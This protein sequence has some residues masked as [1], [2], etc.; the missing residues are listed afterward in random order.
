ML[1]ILGLIYAMY[2]NL[3]LRYLPMKRSVFK[4]TIKVFD[5][6]ACLSFFVVKIKDL[7]QE[8]CEHNIPWDEEFER[9][10]RKK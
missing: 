7:L 5:P 9:S 6:L 10:R 3:H 2:L 8:L 1:I 4:I